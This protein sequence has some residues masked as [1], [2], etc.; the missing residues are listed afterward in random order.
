MEKNKN[1]VI[2]TVVVVIIIVIVVAIFAFGNHASPAA[3]NAPA[4]NA[5]GAA[6][7]TASTPTYISSADGFSAGFSGTPAITDTTFDSPTAGSIPMT[8]YKE[9]ASGSAGAYD[10]VFVDHYPAS[11]T[12]T[13]DYL[14]GAL[15]E[16]T[17]SVNEK[18][19]GSKLMSQA[20]TQFEGMPAITGVVTVPAG[21]ATAD[22]YV[23][24]TTK[25]RN[26]YIVT[27]YGTGQNSFNT[28]L[29]SVSL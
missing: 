5:G 14:T 23:L 3:A 2:I 29:A 26:A 13:S 4:S 18:Y 21:G 15:T 6:A 22:D 9:A 1:A 12:F 28:F 16:F 20:A 17:A 19:P 27:A 10:G 11:Y 8:Q 25:G 7:Q 24:I